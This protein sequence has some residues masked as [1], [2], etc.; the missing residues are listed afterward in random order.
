M[1]FDPIQHGNQL[2]S[3][4][5]ACPTCSLILKQH[6]TQ[7][8]GSQL[9][10]RNYLEWA[11]HALPSTNHKQD[12]GNDWT[13]HAWQSRVAS[14]QWIVGFPENVGSQNIQNGWFI[15]ESPTKLDD[16]GVTLFLETS[17]S[18]QPFFLFRKLC[19]LHF[20]LLWIGQSGE[21]PKGK[22]SHPHSSCHSLRQEATRRRTGLKLNFLK[23]LMT[24]TSSRICP[25][26]S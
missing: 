9:H 26:E 7:Q 1:F 13:Q 5:H 17:I 25:L 18:V 3:F 21:T 24:N 19:V 6:R 2:N 12:L 4:E 20:R 10:M 16:L 11:L 8:A 15:R 23:E 22:S 14:I